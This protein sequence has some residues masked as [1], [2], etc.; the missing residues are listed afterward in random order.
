M[1][2]WNIETKGFYDSRYTEIPEN[3][4]EISD[5]Y[6]DELML[7]CND[8]EFT[9]GFDGVKPIVISKET[10]EEDII[11][12]MVVDA[13]N[14]LTSTDWIKN[15]FIEL[16]M[17]KKTISEDEFKIKYNVELQ[18]MDISREVINTYKKVS[19]KQCHI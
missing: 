10:S 13:Y 14:Y 15:K 6:F 16:V 1:K 12:K 11:N 18:K 5:E 19:I 8:N 4:I 17:I 9:I 2:Y 7:A 3:S